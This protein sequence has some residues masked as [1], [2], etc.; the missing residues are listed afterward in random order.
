MEDKMTT[1]KMDSSQIRKEYTFS[2]AFYPPLPLSNEKTTTQ[3]YPT[4]LNPSPATNDPIF[5]ASMHIRDAVF[6]KEQLCRA[7]EEIDDDDVRSWGWVVYAAPKEQQ[8]K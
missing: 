5:T 1:A 7:E 2:T 6:I 3:L 8:H 4:P